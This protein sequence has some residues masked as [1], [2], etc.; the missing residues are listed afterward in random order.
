MPPLALRFSK[1]VTGLDLIA[2]NRLASGKGDMASSGETSSL[3]VGSSSTTTL[4]QV[5]S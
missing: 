1:N 4:I 5:A 3:L 2:L